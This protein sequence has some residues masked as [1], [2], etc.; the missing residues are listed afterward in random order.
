M[1]EVE[2]YEDGRPVPD[3]WIHVVYV[4]PLDHYVEHLSDT[5]RN[6]DANITDP[7][8]GGGPYEQRFMFSDMPGWDTDWATYIK[9]GHEGGYTF[10]PMS[11][12]AMFNIEYNSDKY[13]EALRTYVLTCA[14]EYVDIPLDEEDGGG[15]YRHCTKCHEH[16]TT[17][18]NY[19]AEWIAQHQEETK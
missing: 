18:R 17:I 11:N 5:I 7:A 12:I 14:H 9:I 16:E 3:G 10:I 1:P 15:T 8:G 13:R 19:E 6:F 2:Y 4:H